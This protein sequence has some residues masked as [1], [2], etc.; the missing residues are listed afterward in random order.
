[1]FSFFLI[2]HHDSISQV[3]QEEGMRCT[4]SWWQFVC[5]FW[6]SWCVWCTTKCRA[7]TLQPVIL[8]IFVYLLLVCVWR[9]RIALSCFKARYPGP[10]ILVHLELTIL[11]YF[12]PCSLT[13]VFLAPGHSSIWLTHLWGSWCVVKG[14][15]SDDFS[16]RNRHP[17]SLSTCHAKPA[18]M[19]CAHAKPQS[20]L[21]SK[22]GQ[23]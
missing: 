4:P 22:R 7:N 10:D 1:M 6:L 14:K 12:G 13:L 15:I 16:R 21:R 20:Q 23:G 5:I 3:G 19:M 9:T 2:K 17:I 11:S 18:I 8:Y